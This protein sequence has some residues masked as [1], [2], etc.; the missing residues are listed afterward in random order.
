MR[1]FIFFPLK[2]DGDSQAGS[3]CFY[4]LLDEKNGH[5]FNMKNYILDR[6]KANS[7]LHI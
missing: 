2:P 7:P 5:K 6:W 1:W 3:T 4:L